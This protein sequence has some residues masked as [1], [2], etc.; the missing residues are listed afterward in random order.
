MR[1]KDRIL[2]GFWGGAFALGAGALSL[3][4]VFSVHKDEPHPISILLE[5]QNASKTPLKFAVV[6]MAEVKSKARAYNNLQKDLEDYHKKF[7]K[8]VLTQEAELRT[9]LEQLRASGSSTDA[10]V[11]P[12]F[13]KDKEA[14]D[15]RV[16]KVE[17]DVQARKELLNQ[18]F[19]QAYKIVDSKLS[20][21][22]EQLSKE[23]NIGLLINTGAA[24]KNGTLDEM[25]VLHHNPLFD[26]TQKI[27]EALD[28][29]IERVEIE[30]L[31]KKK[32]TPGKK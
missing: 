26:L 28:Q 16:A 27:I 20:D 22:I 8:E 3:A 24:I 17:Q 31:E 25:V 19:T 13:L 21:I 23:D 2:Y 29:E 4:Y 1:L 6:D 32:K 15:K 18:K 30:T 7:H 5:R 9:R 11:S 12:Q 10:K 14:F